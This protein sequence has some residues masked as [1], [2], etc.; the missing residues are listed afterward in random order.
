MAQPAERYFVV[1]H[2]H[3]DREWYRPFEHFQLMLGSVVDEV[4]DTLERDPEFASFTLDGQAIV[5]EDYVAVRP[6][7]EPR[8]RALIGAGRIEIGPSY[9]L[10]DE[11]LVG[12]EPLVRNLLIG[13]AVCERF[14]G[15]PSGAGYL[16]DSFG[17]PLQ[18][19]QILAG[20][21][22]ET[23]LFSRGLGDEVDE[24]GIAFH[25]AAADGSSVLALHLL[26]DYSNFADIAGADDAER[27]V[28]G[29]Q[30][31]FGPALG[32]A[33]IRH[34]LLCNGTDHWRIQPEMPAVCAELE[35]RLPR[36]AFA[37]TRYGDYVASLETGQLPAW[38]GELLGSRLWNVLRGVNSA[39]LY[40]KQANER[41]E[42]RL[43]SVETLVALWSLRAGTRFPIEALTFAWRELLKCHPHD[44]I[45]G[46]SCDEVHRDML[47]RY[48]SLERTLDMI[49]E[50]AH[51]G[52]AGHDIPRQIGLVNTLPF[53]RSSLVRPDGA[54]ATLVRLDGFEARTVD[55]AP[56]ESGTSR[57]GEG[58]ESDRF[59]VQ[60]A[61]DGTLAIDDLRS[62]R[63]FEGLHAL[64]DEF[65]MGDLY[66]FC[67][68][69]GTGLRRCARASTRIASDGPL[70][71]ELEL[72]YRCELPAGL[73]AGTRPRRESVEV[74][75]T[76]L[77]RL[78]RG[79]DR[80]EF[81][82]TIDNTACD[83]RLRVVFPIGDA[84]GP[85]RAEGQFA[86]VRRPIEPPKPR[87]EWCEPPD[88]T[89]HAI[90][91]VT[92]GPVALLTRG[93]P[94]YEARRRD[95]AGSE[96]CLTMLRCVGLISRATDEI[97][98]RP[99]GA[100]PRV[101]TP[102]GQCLGRHVLEYALRFDADELDDVALL[103]DSQDYRTPFLLAPPGTELAPT[104]GL[105]GDVVF[106]CLKGAEDG[107]GIV[108]RVF[109]PAAEP[110]I[111]RVRGAF[112][113]ER[114]RLDETGGASVRGGVFEVGPG[115][116]ATLRLRTVTSAPVDRGEDPA[117]PRGPERG[118]ASSRR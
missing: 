93:L 95:A 53:A 41:A 83:H 57:K 65:D 23:F 25:W 31:R 107:D 29:L 106:S 61:D 56:A 12:G 9:V 34:V 20:F 35:R 6:D 3:W 113:V 82:T 58:I 26:A 89:Q 79:S 112:T 59:R 114:V 105:D 84:P 117:R 40:L 60:A 116:I 49:A 30:E 75:L 50:D 91:V 94:E 68:V 47:L 71:S 46:C 32:R 85:V 81:E 69:D 55:L 15:R 13:R 22:I 104:L 33:G 27:R 18:L 78:V 16:P 44:S 87:T 10:P 1:P 108:L 73:G 67:P 77:V 109:N 80:I 28:R 111:A 115:E 48:T 14:G 76:T 102:E 51:G 88:P 86:V 90:G 43:L 96:L 99:L 24:L 63:R 70:C 54:G 42:R 7:N 2:T 64:E 72:A 100:G 118:N 38:T 17:H 11:F 110:A 5:L 92:L 36:S 66:N 45:C 8:L 74:L 4:L 101:A 52:F 62:G 19:P 103:R 97:P 37:I 98:T 39:R 21:G